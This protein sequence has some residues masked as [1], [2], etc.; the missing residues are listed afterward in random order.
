M[1][2]PLSRQ[3]TQAIIGITFGI[4]MFL[5]AIITSWQGYKHKR[6]CGEAN[7]AAWKNCVA[8]LPVG[9]VAI[10]DADITASR[11]RPTRGNSVILCGYLNACDL[12]KLTQIARITFFT[13]SDDGARPFQA[14]EFNLGKVLQTPHPSFESPNI[15]AH[16]LSNVLHQ[17]QSLP[18]S[19][20]RAGQ[21]LN[22]RRSVDPTFTTTANQDA[23]DIGCQN[24]MLG[25]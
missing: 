25:P 23:G 18:G 2:Q 1:S 14:I 22:V 15:T 19:S 6:R 3:S 21:N 13:M 16:A 12:H 17:P 5:L 7:Y 8:T 24:T 9:T 4:V 10:E 20:N 11:H